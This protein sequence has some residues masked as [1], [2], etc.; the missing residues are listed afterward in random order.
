MA[1]A[2]AQLAPAPSTCPLLGPTREAPTAAGKGWRGCMAP[3]LPGSQLPLGLEGACTG[4]GGT[5]TKLGDHA[6]GWGACTSS[7]A[8][9]LG[10]GGES[11]GLGGGM[12]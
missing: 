11:T 6:Q 12:R 4:W 2:Q 1:C 9:A 5:H 3:R 10:W 8:H 7:G